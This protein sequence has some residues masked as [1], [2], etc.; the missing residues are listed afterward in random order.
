MLIII[1]FVAFILH[2]DILNNCII[3]YSLLLILLVI[4]VI[5]MCNM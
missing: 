4:S 2:D 3:V 5:E 1:S